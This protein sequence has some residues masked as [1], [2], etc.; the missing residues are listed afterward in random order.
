M[1]LFISAVLLLASFSSVD[2][3]DLKLAS[4][5]SPQMVLQR[6][7]LLPI[8]GW[9]DAGE[10]ITVGFGNQQKSATAD[11]D[12]KWLVTLDPLTADSTPQK[13]SV[14]SEKADR[15]IEIGDVLVGEVWLGSGQSNMAMLVRNALHF[16]TEQAAA[17]LPLVRVFTEK[18]GASAKPNVDASGQWTVCSPE[19]VG[20]YSATLYFFG[21]ELQQTLNVPVG[22]I[23]SAV[24]GTPIESWIDAQAQRSAADLTPYFAALDANQKQVEPEVAMKRYE[25]SLAQ[26]QAAVQ[27]ARQENKPLPRKP[28]NPV[29]T[30]AKKGNIGGLFNG[31]IAPLIPFAIRGAVW[32]QGE[33]NS[34]PDKAG[35]YQYQLPLLVTD[36][37]SRW[38]DEFPFAWVQL[39]NF[40]GP[41]RDWPTVRAGMLKTL[42]LPKTGMAITIDVG[43]TKDIHPKNKQAVG[44][45]LALWA[46]GDVYGQQVA[47][48][49]GPLPESHQVK[50]AAIVVTF[51]H[52]DGGLVAKSGELTGFMIA[53]K[54]QQW[55][56]AEA[57]IEGDKVIVASA[58]VP[59]PTTVR[60]AWEND[61]IC[62]LC[63]AAGLPA[64]P[65]QTE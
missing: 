51:R 47:A 53:G 16:E 35:Y 19:T 14:H 57:R 38:G 2:A 26:W 45:R 55:K 43:D 60:Y 15:R 52:C 24:G 54:D 61:P 65:F 31:K 3:S 21:R 4:I 59:Q 34:M 29:E 11:V 23:V 30:A 46:L 36:W 64:T 9:A 17:N 56:T 20:S 37:R 8:W 28:Q 48:T 41:G 63:N 18:S 40:G 6:D 42:A 27:T 7:K 25:R 33:A 10:K 13:L 1:R 50:G 39:P 49:S 12:G 32:Y 44:K 22:L 62:N 58:E 5:F